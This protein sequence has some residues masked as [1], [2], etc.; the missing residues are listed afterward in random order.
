MITRLTA[1]HFTRFCERCC[2]GNCQAG[3]LPEVPGSGRQQDRPRQQLG[4]DCRRVLP[5][6]ESRHSCRGGRGR[7]TAG[8]RSCGGIRGR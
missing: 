5:D 7:C 2:H 8:E 1:G 6:H 4:P 3:N